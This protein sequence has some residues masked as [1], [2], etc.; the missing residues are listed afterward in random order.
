MSS[1]LGIYGHISNSINSRP[2][3]HRKLKRFLSPA[4]TTA[5]VDGLGFLF[6]KCTQSLLDKY[7]VLKNER[8][9]G[10]T[11]MVEKG[12]FIRT[13]LMDDLHNVA[14]DM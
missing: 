6:E 14:L 10:A 8:P 2:E 13:D 3:P 11:G 7:E 5:Y 1:L 12:H 4:F 9:I